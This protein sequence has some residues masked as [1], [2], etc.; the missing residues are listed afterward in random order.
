MAAQTLTP[1]FS[2]LLMDKFGLTALFPYST[3][4]VGLAFVTMLF[5]RH[6]DSKPQ[7]KAA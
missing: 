6:G 5:V 7:K 2:G 4:F 3:V 1:Y